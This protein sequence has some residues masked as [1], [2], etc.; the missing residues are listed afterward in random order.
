MSYLLVLH[1]SPSLFIDYPLH[2]GNFGKALESLNQALELYCNSEWLFHRATFLRLRN[3]C[4]DYEVI[5]AYKR[6]LLSNPPE[7]KILPQLKYMHF[8]YF[9]SGSHCRTF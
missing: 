4:P 5:D 2:L 8:N 7:S 9:S 6:F 1:H 3:D